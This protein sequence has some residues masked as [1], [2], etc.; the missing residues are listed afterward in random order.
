M[1]DNSVGLDRVLVDIPIEVAKN[2]KSKKILNRR[3]PAKT[4]LFQ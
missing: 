4:K 1:G 2:R 3:V